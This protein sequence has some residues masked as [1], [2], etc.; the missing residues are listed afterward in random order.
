M[1]QALYMTC[2]SKDLSLWFLTSLNYSG[3]IPFE[4]HIKGN[5][6]QH[7]SEVLCT[8]QDLR[9]LGY[10]NIKPVMSEKSGMVNDYWVENL[11]QN[12]L[13]FFFF[14]IINCA[15]F[16]FLT[17][18]K[19]VLCPTQETWHIFPFLVCWD[20]VNKI[21]QQVRWLLYYDILSK[22]G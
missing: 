22:C 14:F 18:Q 15:E 7:P 11:K 6:I 13:I 17:T 9:W 20:R 21:L 4:S 2:N 12:V 19:R 1:S 8:D 16:Q 5:E 3:F 10:I